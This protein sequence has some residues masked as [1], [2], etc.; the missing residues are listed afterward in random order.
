MKQR[1]RY[2]LDDHRAYD[3]RPRKNNR[4]KSPRTQAAIYRTSGG[5][6]GN[7]VS[8]GSRPA[9]SVGRA[10]AGAGAR[11]PR[12]NT[13]AK[14][15]DGGVSLTTYAPLEHWAETTARTSRDAAKSQPAQ[16]TRANPK[17]R[18][19]TGIDAEF[20]GT[21]QAAM[22]TRS[23]LATTGAVASVRGHGPVWLNETSQHDHMTYG[24]NR[25]QF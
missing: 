23:I 3:G 22:Q 9:A 7:A 19:A 18:A 13:N 6:G 16:I 10:G 14:S 15:R 24:P 17:G 5:S 2:A 12:Y 8:G 1:D 11:R 21:R 4:A 20:E 25:N